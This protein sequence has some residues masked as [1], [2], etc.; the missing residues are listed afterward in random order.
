MVGGLAPT[1]TVHADRRGDRVAVF[2]ST[3]R[4]WMESS[5]NTVP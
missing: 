5:Q 2:G 3:R 4:E 1:V